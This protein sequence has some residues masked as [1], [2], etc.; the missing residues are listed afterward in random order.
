MAE[1]L[2]YPSIGPRGAVLI[3]LVI[4]ST[5]LGVLHILNPRATLVSTVNISLAGIFLGLGYVLTGRLAIPIGLHITWNFFQGSVFGFPVSGMDTIGAT[6]VE[7][8]Q[9]GPDAL[10]GGAFGPEAGLIGIVAMV[11][12]RLL[13]VARVRLRSGK[14]TRQAAV[15]EPPRRKTQVVEITATP[16]PRRTLP[17]LTTRA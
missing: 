4:S 6:F 1:G 16:S 12:G 11:T 13:V 7:T 3:A 14:T 15:A 2:N 8:R 5:I 17:S 10:T 9:G